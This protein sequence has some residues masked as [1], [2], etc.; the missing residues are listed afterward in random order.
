[1]N[2]RLYCYCTAIALMTLE[3]MLAMAAFAK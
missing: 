1:M 3:V 2:D